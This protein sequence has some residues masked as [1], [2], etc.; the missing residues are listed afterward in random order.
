M[1]ESRSKAILLSLA[2]QGLNAAL[3]WALKTAADFKDYT[4]IVPTSAHT[5]EGV[6]DILMMLVQW[7]QKLL[8]DRIMFS[9][10]VQCTVLEIKNIEGLG[11]TADVI[12]ANGTLRRGDRIVMCGFGGPVVTRVREL[13]TPRPLRALGEFGKDYSS[14]SGDLLHDVD[15]DGW[16]DVLSISFVESELCWFRD[17]PPAPVKAF[18]D[19]EYPDMRGKDEIAAIAGNAGYRVLATHS[20]A[21]ETWT[22]G[23]Y[24]VLEP[25]AKTLV[26]HED[27]TVRAF[28]KQTLREI[29]TFRTKEGSY[30]Y[31]FY[32]LQRT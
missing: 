9:S 17:D 12:L 18:F 26:D 31:V 24:D 1:F 10:E 21:D 3:Y 23:F 2:E 28:A 30:G 5:G 19:S 8:R 4:S 32:V 7:S 29:E 27:E 11:T 13:L 25:R 15:V 22:A 14:S 6:A 20:L 16:L